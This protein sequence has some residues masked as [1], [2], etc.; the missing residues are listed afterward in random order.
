M[1]VFNAFNSILFQ[2]KMGQLL[3]DVV[4][5]IWIVY[6]SHVSDQFLELLPIDGVLSWVFP[7]IEDSTIKLRVFFAHWPTFVFA[8]A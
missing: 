4:G 8:L 7:I 3:E 5:T 1:V 2:L 6:V